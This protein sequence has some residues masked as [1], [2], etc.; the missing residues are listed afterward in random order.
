MGEGTTHAGATTRASNTSRAGETAHAGGAAEQQTSAQLVEG[1][2][3]FSSVYT[4][5]LPTCTYEAVVRHPVYCGHIPRTGTW[6][7]FLDLYAE[8]T[9]VPQDRL[10]FRASMALDAVRAALSDGEKVYSFEYRRHAP[11]ADLTWCRAALIVTE[12]DDDGTPRRLILTLSDITYEKDFAARMEEMRRTKEI[13]DFSMAGTD[14]FLWQLDLVNDQI[15]FADNPYT[16]KRKAE[17]GYPD[18]V[19]HASR[20]IMANV[21]PES[22][23]TMQR[24]FDDI[25]A[26]KSWTE[27]DIHFRAGG[28]KGYTVCRISY[29]VITNDEGVPVKAY[30]CEQNVTD[31]LVAR[32]AFE[33]EMVRF[34]ELDDTEEGMLCF[35]ASLTRN[36]VL[37]TSGDRE[38]VME[39]ASYDEAITQSYFLE[40]ETDDDESLGHALQ[41]G[42]LIARYAR[43]ERHLDL[44]FRWLGGDTWTW[45]EAEAALVQNPATSDIELFFY[46]HDE[47]LAKM[48][49]LIVERLTSVIY[50]HISVIS[51]EGRCYLLDEMEKD[52]PD[53]E[54]RS[55]A[56]RAHGL[57]T[58]R[59][60][61]EMRDAVAR[62]VDFDHVVSQLEHERIY[63]VNTT[64]V[65][66]DGS[67]THKMRQYCWLDED[68]ELLMVSVTDVTHAVEKEKESNIRMRDA[69]TAAE[70]ANAAKS[71]FL[72]RMSH[73]I[74]TPMNAII[75]FS[76]LLLN[77]AD[78]EARVKDQA[79][80]ILVSS[81]HLLGLI[82]DILDMSKI[83]TGKI[84]MNSREFQLSESLEVIDGIMRPQMRERHQSFGIY[85]SG[86]RHDTF[87][88]DDQRIQQILINV[89]SNATKYTAEGG[90]VTLRVRSLPE[91]S[92]RYE[93][94]VFEVADDGRGMTEEY[95][96]VIFEPFSREQFETQEAAQGTGL[97]MA[98]TKNLVNMMGG[99]I[100]VK[101]AL[102]EGSTF[103][104]S[105]PLRLPDADEDRVFWRTHSLT[106]ML[107]V[108]DEEEICQNV[109]ETMST[110]G[111]R[112]EYALDGATS[113]TML[114]DAH[115]QGDDF[116][117]VLLDWVM[118]GM[119]GLETARAI[120]RTTVPETLIIILTAY[121]YGEIEEEARAAGVGGFIPKPFF[122]HRLEE[123]VL[124]TG[125]H[126]AKDRTDD[127]KSGAATTAAR[128]MSGMRVL[129][130]EDNEL[131][132]ALLGEVLSAR[133]IEAD[134]E[135][136]GKR[137]L[138]RF[139]Q[140][141]PGAYD[142]ILM[143]VQMPVMNGY[144][145]T[146]A[147]R[148]LADDT[149]LDASKRREAAAIPIVAMTANAFT[150]DIQNALDAGMNAHVAKPIDLEVLMRVIESVR[151]RHGAGDGR[152]EDGQ[153]TARRRPQERPG[154]SE[155]T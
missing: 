23:A 142:L 24:I 76:T 41:R 103:T 48:R 28:D 8:R 9:V 94:V 152:Q 47:T 131:N 59:I 145:A 14:L 26:G 51:T 127:A 5:D 57:V 17:I 141:A 83:E 120:R 126:G 137:A 45:V 124:E 85:V 117:L 134:I 55:Y 19:P 97:G 129:A 108:D 138:G 119:D 12:K 73:D 40:A 91:S 86:V 53:Q 80:K 54:T 31:Q 11:D 100:S 123:A 135:N 104:V 56:E 106:H 36:E 153:E 68:R 72:S 146:R 46:T 118:P 151:A 112:V 132:A 61:A 140:A 122:L 13:Y 63:I 74:R 147:I 4:V 58:Q 66:P 95:Q 84:Q 99:M 105:I 44:E 81:N 77:S 69:L 42:P 67:L 43:G 37:A 20:Y 78:D 96:K 93:T 111:V 139:E 90:S 33:R 116:D 18:V 3:A 25:H 110:S 114:E 92:G 155:M 125:R 115:A 148:A 39:G 50:D 30:G 79:K 21:M 82:N 98:I 35:R 107:V 52:L 75:G 60:P 144:E 154:E 150:D 89:L 128:D 10:A 22:V 109:A 101:S 38:G 16:L 87:V 149:R 136:N 6:A 49:S 102:G 143:D 2:D 62:A 71:D 7:Q 65:E 34:S 133:G 113:L 32:D 15:T 64:E 27:G 1:R 88:G 130:A 70:A 121:D 29:H